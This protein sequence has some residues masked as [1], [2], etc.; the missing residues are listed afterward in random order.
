M[1]KS[2]LRPKF[3]ALSL[4]SLGFVAVSTMSFAADAQTTL[5]IS[6]RSL[7]SPYQV[8]YKE[9]SEAYAKSVGS[10]LH[11]LTTEANSQKGMTDIRAEVTR[12]GGNV[13]FASTQTTQ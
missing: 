7:S 2:M 8:M 11:V 4:W 9:G 6:I 1:N 3:T 13:A 12:T 10:P 5:A